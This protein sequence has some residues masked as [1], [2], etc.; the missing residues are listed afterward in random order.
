MATCEGDISTPPDRNASPRL[1]VPIPQ[2]VV[3]DSVVLDLSAHFTD[4]DGD[5]LSFTAMSSNTAVVRA[6]L[7]GAAATLIAVVKGSAT[8]T[9]TA[10]DPDGA[11]ATHGFAVTV[12]NR[13]PRVVVA[14]P[15]AEALTGDQVTI[16]VAGY[17]T[18]PDQD[19]LTFGAETTEVGVATVS[20]TGDEVTVGAISPGVA[21]I[22]VT[23]TDPEGLVAAQDFHLTVPNRA[24][25]ATDPL[26]DIELEVGEEVETRM[27]G[28]FADPDGEELA[29]TASSS[30]EAVTEVGVSGADLTVGATA[31]G[32][33]TIT[34]TAT[35]PGG[36]VAVQGFLV[37]VP[38]RAPEAVDSLPDIEV[39]VGETV[40]LELSRFFMDPD[41]DDL[42]FAATSSDSV[43]AVAETSGAEARVRAVAKGTAT[44][45]VSATDTEGLTARLAFSV[46]VPNRAPSA[47]AAL[48]DIEVEVGEATGTDLGAHFTDPDGDI[49]VFAAESSDPAVARV[50]V[51][52]ERVTVGAVAKGA[53]TVTV[54]ATDTEGLAATQSL[55][56]TVPNR[57]PRVT[58]TLPDIEVEVGGEASAKMSHHFVDPDGDGLT[59]RAESSQGGVAGVAV[60]GDEVLVR[61]VA[62]G[63]ATI[64]VTATDT[65]GLAAT[66]SFRVAVPNR[67]PEAVDSLPDIEVEVGETVGLELSRFFMDPDGDDLVFAATSSDTLRAVAE[68]SGA[69]ARV[70]AV[71]K[72]TATIEVSATDTEGLTARLAFSV[73]VPNRAPSATEALPDVEVEVGEATGAALGA[74]FADPDGDI[75]AFAAESSHPAVATVSVST[76]RFT[77]TAVSKGAATVTVTATDPE[78]LKVAQSFRVTVPNRAPE[79]A[80]AL[81]DLELHV[82]EESATDMSAH[83]V[84]P[85]GDT[86]F[87]TAESSDSMVA[88]A[89]V[90]G[91]R[92]T[93]SALAWGTTTVTVTASDPEDLTATGVFQVTVPNRGPRVH[94]P[95]PYRRLEVGE[96]IEMSLLDHFADP[97]G[98]SLTFRAWSSDSSVVSVGVAGNGLTL[99]AMAKGGVEIT[100][101]A[102]DPASLEVEANFTVRVPNR[103]PRSER[104][105]GDQGVASGGQI[106][107]K[108]SRYFSDPD[109]DTLSFAVESSD[110]AV[111][112]ALVRRGEVQVRGIAPGTA[113][114]TLKATDPEGLTATQIFDVVVTRRNRAPRPQG[115]IP[116]ESLEAGAEVTTDLSDYFTDPDG[117]DLA[118]TAESSDPTVA[119]AGISD[120]QLTTTAVDSGTA[121]ITV[122][123]TDPGGLTAAQ[124]FA[125]AVDHTPTDGAPR[126]NGYI[127]DQGLYEGDEY[128]LDVSG[129]FTDPDGDPLTFAATSSHPGVATAAAAAADVTVRAISAGRATITVTATDPGGLYATQAFSVLVRRRGA[130]G[131]FDISLI[132]TDAV[133]VAH[134]PTLEA[135]ALWWRSV[136]SDTEWDDVAINGTRTCR[137]TEVDLDVVDDLAILVNVVEMDG[138]LG[139]VARAGV[140]IARDEGHSHA[141]VLGFIRFDKADIDLLE[142]YDDLW[143][144]MV[145][146]TTH[147]LGFGP[148][149]VQLNLLDQET[150]PHFTGPRAIAAFDAAGGADYS[151]AKVPT[152]P[153]RGHWRESVFG[154]ELMS[155]FLF[156][157]RREPLS[158]ITLEALTDM[159]YYVDLSFADDYELDGVESDVGAMDPAR[160]INL[161]DDFD[162]G[163]VMIIDRD[164]NIVR[165]I[166]G[167]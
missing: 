141:P 67:A 162:R 48:P 32:T 150:D 123:A 142:Q 165:V 2:Q 68:T 21:T 167:R 75:L 140:C 69:E 16:R 156:V 44:I 132:F 144:I 153:G 56:V 74:H 31:K 1:A 127:T 22:T 158:A 139:T 106:I 98:D 121:T 163:P 93:V 97:D 118:F 59:Y 14:I 155:S 37:T 19:S 41:G 55:R 39:E 160:I 45:E 90:S 76:N 38:N 64:A 119:T 166:P 125:V 30:R 147:V 62:K 13:A 53:A 107:L 87:F 124:S 129:Y 18:E 120:D 91:D 128:S 47:T 94:T 95:M 9:V 105:I 12:P 81:P 29:F 6:E 26:P 161:A 28:H 101:M 77:V 35:D 61:A 17:F 138:D 110:T 103:A 11:T 148:R 72:G 126:P 146:E 135:A 10:T 58:D 71:A 33:A 151:G 36:L 73:R 130:S 78:G 54:T 159:G 89:H 66:Q 86:L 7:A 108:P 84:D 24:P 116:D 88:A 57:A 102:T 133:P 111:A 65:E 43:R 4:P 34:V 5:A 51:T 15:D 52:G 20:V 63:T 114:M 137:G 3:R 113:T 83:F 8:V 122:T 112:T 164:G 115:N 49:L 60:S 42:V 46:R 50:S 136:L 80:N 96:E 40:G 23:A 104:T 149:W 85:D 157:N 134:R 100:V 145:H 25:R 117:D 92:V 82:G 154:S 131:D 99:R 79:A 27:S 152:Q 143:E 70:R 109:G